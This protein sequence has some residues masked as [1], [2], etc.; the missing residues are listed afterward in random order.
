MQFALSQV[1]GRLA[2]ARAS[3]PDGIDVSGGAAHPVGLPDAAVRAHRRRSAGAAR[4]GGVHLA[5]APGRAAGR[6]RGRGGGRPGA[7]DHRA[8]RPGPTDRQSR[9]HVP[10]GA[11]H[12][13]D[14]SGRGHRTLRPGLPAVRDHRLRP[15]QH[16]GGGR[17]GRGDPEWR[18]ARCGWPTLAWSVTAPRTC[19]KSWRAMEGRPRWSTSRASRTATRSA[20]RLPS[21]RRWTRSA[22][23]CRPASCSSR[24]TTRRRWCGT[25]W[26]ACATRCCSAGRSPCWCCSCSSAS[27]GPPRP[28]RSPC[29]SRSRSPCSASPSRAT[30][31]T[32]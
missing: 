30:R 12:L 32:S 2:A 25:R 6:R 20:C 10:G 15:H 23:C 26:R 8:A 13:R 5:P 21:G 18:R 3:L 24:C 11:G 1:Q 9:Q 31:S 29:P 27:G 7:A 28:P 19:F 4:S 22:P 17:P 14:R 16:P